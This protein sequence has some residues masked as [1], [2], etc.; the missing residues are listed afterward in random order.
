[1]NSEFRTG[2][3]CQ[4]NRFKFK[5]RQ[6]RNMIENAAQ[7]SSISTC[8]GYG[9]GTFT[10]G[11]LKCSLKSVKSFLGSRMVES[12]FFE[13]DTGSLGR[14]SRLSLR[15]GLS[16]DLIA[17]M[18]LKFDRLER[19]AQLGG[20]CCI[21]VLPSGLLTLRR[22]DRTGAIRPPLPTSV[23]IPRYSVRFADIAV[24]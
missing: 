3:V 23:N 11:S 19:T 20:R 10:F 16:A 1:M 9:S 5:C 8:Q 22:C 18:Y 4:L 12:Y 14:G 13:K 6:N 2:I 21:I 7:P 15:S 24:V 17:S